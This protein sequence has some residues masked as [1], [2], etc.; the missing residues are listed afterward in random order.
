MPQGVLRRNWKMLSD[1][2][3]LNRLRPGAVC[4]YPFRSGAAVLVRGDFGMLS[5]LLAYR[6]IRTEA[7]PG[8]AERYE[9][10]VLQGEELL[11]DRQLL[12]AAA[13]KLAENGILLIAAQNRFALRFLCGD[14][15]GGGYVFQQPEGRLQRNRLFSRKEM[16]DLLGDCGFAEENIR[17]YSMYPGTYDIYH[18]IVRWGEEPGEDM[19][20]RYFPISETPQTVFLDEKHQIGESA[21]AGIFHQTAGGYL[22]ECRKGGISFADVKKAT[23]S[24]DRD[25]SLASATVVGKTRTRKI[26][27]FPAGKVHLEQTADILN[28][29]ADHGIPTLRQE[30]LPSGALEMESMEAPTGAL[31]LKQLLLSGQK[32]LFL[33][34]LDAFVELIRRSSDLTEDNSGCSVLR[35]GAIDMVPLNCFYKDGKYLFFD[36]EFMQPMLRPEVI[37]WRSVVILY[38]DLS[39]MSACLPMKELWR[40]Y[41][42]EDCEEACGREAKAFQNRLLREDLFGEFRRRHRP[43]ES[44]QNANRLR[45][46]FSARSFLEHVF[47]PEEIQDHPIW[48]YGAGQY[49][50]RFLNL[51][52]SRAAIAGILKT[53][54]AQGESFCGIPVSSPKMI[55]QLREDEK[56]QIVI[57]VKDYA[58]IV[59]MLEAFGFDRW[60]LYAPWLSTLAPQRHIP[61]D[62]SEKK[63]RKGYVAGVFDLFHAG[64]L[65]L[66]RK[67]KEMCVYLIVGV[68]ADAASIRDK[69]KR[70][71]V[72]ETERLELVRACRYVDEAYLIPVGDGSTQ[73]AYEIY[74]FDVQFTGDDHRD[75]IYWREAEH[76]LRAHGA[77]LVYFKYTEGVSSSLRRGMIC[78]GEDDGRQAD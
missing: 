38:S 76:F 77:D 28:R 16:M 64:H 52:G 39:S 41:G 48:L 61:F 30:I 63:Y 37:I 65:N 50:R 13:G 47:Q 21:A 25:P 24:L 31:Y 9:Y 49:A 72:P 26:P 78:K 35:E 59:K 40:R 12:S 32:D 62:P 2:E 56:A 70:P 60:K 69:G 5:E 55:E 43:P 23:V 17:T 6:N 1:R 33:K 44:L 54:A 20:S 58:D 36:Q 29:L 66:L 73:A 53:K 11:S 4:W 57:C 14:T 18:L 71:I 51:Y 15:Y 8:R 68:V 74:D 46:N 3:A 10:I 67:A 42:M 7:W 22:Y 19:E 45:M 34:E 27:L 75:D